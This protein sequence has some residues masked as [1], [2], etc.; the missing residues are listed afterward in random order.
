MNNI[1]IVTKD[2]L[3]D[4]VDFVHDGKSKQRINLINQ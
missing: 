4:D 3:K 2:L 1:N